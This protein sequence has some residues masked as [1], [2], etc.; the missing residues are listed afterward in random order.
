MP[1][2]PKR[3]WGCLTIGLSLVVGFFVLNFGMNWWS[4]RPKQLLDRFLDVAWSEDITRLETGF[5]GGMDFTAHIYL[6][7]DVATIEGILTDGGFTKTSVPADS[8]RIG[9]AKL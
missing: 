2:E 7:A 1:K 4:T 5:V 6:E 3:K 8:R 9:S